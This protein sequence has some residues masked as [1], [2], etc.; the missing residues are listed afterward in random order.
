MCIT[1]ATAT[2][3]N[4]AA[5]IAA[6]AGVIFC[7]PLSTFL[8]RH[9]CHHVTTWRMACRNFLRQKLLRAVAVETG[10]STVGGAG[11]GSGH[12]FNVVLQCVIRYFINV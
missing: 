11:A 6:A 5:A 1:T 2:V 10:A 4:A 9:A 12:T 7:N 8:C 3:K